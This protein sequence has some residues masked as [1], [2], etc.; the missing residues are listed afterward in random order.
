MAPRVSVIIP[1]YNGDR[2]IAEAVRSVL[3]QT[4]WDYE[5][6]VVDDGSTDN[7]AVVLQPYR[8]RIRYV[9]QTNQGVAAARNHG[10][11]IAQGEFVA[12]LDQDDVCL[13]E[14]LSL[15]VACFE[16]HPTIGMV[17][18]GWRLVDHQARVLSDVKPWHEFPKLDLAGWVQRMPVFLSAMLFRRSWLEQVGGLSQAFKQ[19]CDVDLVQRLALLGCETAWV[20]QVTV[21]YRQHDQ[22]DSLN[23]LIQA[24]EVWAV[25]ELFFGRSDLPESVRKIEPQARYYTLVWMAWRLYYT[26]HFAEM[27]Q[28]LEHSC[29]YTPFAFTETLLHWVNSFTAYASEYGVRFDAYKL[30]QSPEWQRLTSVV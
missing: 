8:D 23:T 22:N 11:A 14:K 26:G 18:S 2:Y 9:Y 3:S 4:Y 16:A 10:I 5:I 1:A 30:I 27:A 21:L 19:A 28:C 7:T 25:Q 15:Q 13:P 17:H 6:V 12:L 29:R 24:K 20:K